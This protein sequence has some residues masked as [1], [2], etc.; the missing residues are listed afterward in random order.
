[1]KGTVSMA[2]PRRPVVKD[3]CF[4]SAEKSLNLNT[5]NNL[6][7]PPA[8]LAGRYQ[9]KEF[10]N[11]RFR[12]AA[13]IVLLICRLGAPVFGEGSVLCFGVDGR[14]EL[15]TSRKGRCVNCSLASPLTVSAPS[16]EDAMSI[17]DR[18]DICFD[19]PFS[20]NGSVMNVSV[21]RDPAP[22]KD[23]V[24]HV[25]CHAFPSTIRAVAPEPACPQHPPVVDTT[26]R[27]LSSVVC[28]I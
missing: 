17:S 18:Y 23:T 26:S 12:T 24:G 15:E 8:W 14:V 9:G 11:G 28:L 22:P 21:C 25:D 3:S 1:L 20:M 19:V 6:S 2:L 5:R 27:L 10:M 7:T 16:S 13:V 4:D